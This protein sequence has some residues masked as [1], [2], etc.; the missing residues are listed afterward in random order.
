M[1]HLELSNENDSSYQ[2]MSFQTR[3]SDHYLFTRVRLNKRLMSRR[4]GQIT[5]P[6]SNQFVFGMHLSDR[7]GR[8]CSS[9]FAA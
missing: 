3:H 9:T 5:Y 4:D 8:R 6:K 2:L 7:D 1:R